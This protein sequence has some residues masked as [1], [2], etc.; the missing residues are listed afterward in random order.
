MSFLNP[1]G[2]IGLLSLPVIVGLHMY[3]ER[4]RSVT[5]S[6]LRLWSFLEVQLRGAKPQQIRLT[7]LL[8]LDLMIAILLSLA[9]SRPEVSLPYSFQQ[10]K[11]VIVLLDD[12]LSMLA[13]DVSP[14]R[15]WQAK[16]DI[17]D[18][19]DKLDS[20]DLISLITFGGDVVLIGDTRQISVQTLRSELLDLEAGNIGVDI[21]P[22][23]SMAFSLSNE[24]LP[25]ELHIFTDGAFEEPDISISPS[26]LQWHIFGK[27]PENQAVVALDTME[28]GKTSFQVFATIVNFSEKRISRDLILLSDGVEVNSLAIE[29]EPYAEFSQIWNIIGRSKMVSVALSGEDNLR[30]DNIASLGVTLESPVRVALISDNPEPVDKAIMSVLNVDLKTYNPSEY[31]NGMEFDLFV[32]RGFL[33]EEWPDGNVLILDP[34]EGSDL[35]IINGSQLIVSQPQ[36]EEHELLNGIDFGGVRWGAVWEPESWREDFIPVLASGEFPIMLTGNIGFTEL[37]VFLP[38]LDDGNFINHPAFPIFISNVISTARE[39]KFPGQI[40]IGSELPLPSIDEF[41][42]IIIT[43]SFGDV[44]DV[45]NQN[46]FSFRE[47]KVPGL[48]QIEVTDWDGNSMEFEISVNAGSMDE[49]NLVPQEWA[50]NIGE[51]NSTQGFQDTLAVDLTPWILSIVMVLVFV[52]VW[53]AWR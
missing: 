38:V 19:L 44:F 1:I 22:A 5:V 36:Y 13:T 4:N 37:V 51:G 43:N 42:Q 29:L 23:L 32:F 3:R 7:W 33:P 34:P 35:L 2:L 12:S 39:F 10:E 17:L 30:E 9:F 48:Y 50:K 46:D 8:I 16:K 26:L 11:H 14:S 52:E 6:S 21:I 49:S 31:L 28:I 24:Q 53:R 25:V 18:L 45:R 47:M 27:N 20:R 40:V 15:F 41:P